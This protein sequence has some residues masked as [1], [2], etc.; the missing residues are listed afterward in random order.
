M[1]KRGT[2]LGHNAPLSMGN[3]TTGL[4]II[5]P[6]TCSDLLGRLIDGIRETISATPRCGVRKRSIFA[7][8]TQTWAN[9][10]N[11]PFPPPR[12]G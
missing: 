4:L 9:G 2:V 8:V 5:R 10:T 3:D 12:S 6:Q 7:S 11:P 1:R